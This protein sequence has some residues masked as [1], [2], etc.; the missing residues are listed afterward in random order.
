VSSYGSHARIRRSGA[1]VN[2]GSARTGPVRACSNG[3]AKGPVMSRGVTG[4]A[5]TSIPVAPRRSRQSSEVAGLV[6]PSLVPERRQ[7]V[8][9]CSPAR[10]CDAGRQGDRRSHQQNGREVVGGE[11]PRAQDPGR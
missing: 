2:A 3:R 1:G 7:R 4:V 8:E 10:W 9:P 11:I 5:A 6:I